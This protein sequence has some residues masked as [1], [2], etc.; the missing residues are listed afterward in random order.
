MPFVPA[1]TKTHLFLF[2]APVLPAAVRLPAA[3]AL[4]VQSQ[5]SGCTS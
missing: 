1:F 2:P 5:L 4:H 3:A